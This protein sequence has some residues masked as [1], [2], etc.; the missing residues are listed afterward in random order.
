MRH[1]AGGMRHET[2]GRSRRRLA[3][4]KSIFREITLLTYYS[5]YYNNI[6]Q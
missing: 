1:E 3:Q 4:R 6:L 5:C 2:G